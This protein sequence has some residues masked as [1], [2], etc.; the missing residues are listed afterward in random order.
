M[1]SSVVS[2]TVRFIMALRN[3]NISSD[4]QKCKLNCWF[5][6]SYFMH[7]N[8][9]GFDFFFILCKTF[10]SY[11]PFFSQLYFRSERFIPAITLEEAFC[12]QES[13]AFY[14]AVITFPY[15]LAR[16]TIKTEM[17]SSFIM[18]LCEELIFF[19]PTSF[20]RD[21]QRI[22]QTLHICLAHSAVA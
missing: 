12:C 10:M 9:T 3:G 11:Q 7:S 14:S 8:F 13:L 18:P 1:F 2:G 19:P 16:S 20:F 15:T 21:S 4:L 5:R 17:F 6:L 22:L